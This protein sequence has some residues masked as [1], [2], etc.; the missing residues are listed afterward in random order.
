MENR[1]STVSNA[2]DLRLSPSLPPPS[3]YLDAHRSWLE[4]VLG[5]ELA[6]TVVL[7]LPVPYG[8]FIVEEFLKRTPVTSSDG[9]A[10]V[11][12]D[13]DRTDLPSMLLPF[14]LHAPV[15]SAGS[16]ANSYVSDMKVWRSIIVRWERVPMEPVELDVEPVRHRTDETTS[17]GWSVRWRGPALALW[18]KGLRH[19][20]VFISIPFVSFQ[21]GS[22]CDDADICGVINSDERNEALAVLRS[23]FVA[24]PNVVEVFGGRNIRLAKVTY[25]WDR[26]VLSP[27]V[28]HK[29]RDDFEAFLSRRR[30]F[31]EQRLA[32]KRGYLLCGPP[33]N[34]KTSII[35]IM[36]AHPDI[37]SFS[38]DFS[39]ENLSNQTL[40]QLFDVATRNEPSLVIF[41]DLDRLY[42]PSA[43]REDENR[44]RITLQH[45]FNVMDG[46]GEREGVIVVATANDVSVLDPALSQRP[47]RFDRV[48]DVGPPNM[49]MR[50]DYLKRL[51]VAPEL[52]ET[53]LALLAEASDGFSFAHL[54]AMHFVASQAAFGRPDGQDRVEYADLD[55]A[56]RQ[57]RTDMEQV[58]RAGHHNAG[59]RIDADPVRAEGRSP[60]R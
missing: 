50:L 11:A 37:R 18:C 43:S 59:F 24:A 34:G 48:V 29:V 19:G 20:I 41:E 33:G 6:Q 60:R 23:A 54:A 8:D 36:A 56:T 42:G 2:I 58:K 7:R 32:Y 9:A 1:Y 5:C 21:G 53:E 12:A 4:R 16:A 22:A 35:K 45:L 38:L 3:V 52:S 47:G 51:K 40:T 57:V 44:T 27:E 55:N 46:V 26:L 15:S 28:L 49:A 17:D 14:R 30:W 10:S 31:I 13:D 25:D 39:N